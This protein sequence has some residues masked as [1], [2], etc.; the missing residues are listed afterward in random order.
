[1]SA[2]V[3][4]KRLGF[5]EFFGSSPAA[6]KSRCFYG[7]PISSSDFGFASD[8][9]VSSLLRMFPSINREVVETILK[10]HEDKVDDA[11]KSLHALC[12]V[13][14]STMNGAG[15]LEPTFHS[16]DDSIKGVLGAQTS[17]VKVEA[18]S[19]NSLLHDR[20]SWVEFFVQEMMNTSNW[21][22]V[23]GRISRVLEAFERSVLEQPTSSEDAIHREQQE[24]ASLKEQLACLLRDNQ[25]LKKAVAIQHERNLEND[26]RLKEVQQLKHIISQ[27]EEQVR[28][29]ELHN[30]T[31]RV[32]LQR[33]QE[34]T[35]IPSQFHP[36]I[37]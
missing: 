19:N 10:S 34:D 24:I 13:D 9:K 15:V 1:M 29:L 30:Y 37:F 35:S 33:A 22:E 4:G 32:H 7:S 36:D 2:G 26:E 27:Y 11:I 25:I 18:A 21:D 5:E 8:D 31:L 28:T 20:S 17:E 6:K 3:C 14:G 16:N 12:L 23:R